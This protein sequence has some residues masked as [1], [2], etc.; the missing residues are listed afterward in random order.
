MISVGIIGSGFGVRGH[1][2]AFHRTGLARVKS[3]YSPNLSRLQ[4]LSRLH[5]I[6]IAATRPEEVFEDP[7]IDLVVIASPNWTHEHYMRMGV[8]N[9]KHLL[10]EKPLGHTAEQSER[11][12]ALV[13]PDYPKW[14]AINHQ[15]RF[16]PYIRFMK[17]VSFSGSLGRIIGLRVA[18]ISTALANDRL[19][20]NWS[21]DE[22]SGG[23]VR[24][25]MGSHLVD[26]AAF[27]TGERIARIDAQMNP[28]RYTRPRG[29]V[30]MSVNV[31]STFL[32]F[33]ETVNGTNVQL[34][35]NAAAFSGTALDIDIFFDRGEIRF[36]LDRKIRIFK[37]G[38]SVV[39][40]IR[41]LPCVTAEERANN[42]SIFGGSV[43]YFVQQLVQDIFD[44]RSRTEY[45]CSLDDAIYVSKVLDA[46][47]A[48]YRTGR[49]VLIGELGG[50]RESS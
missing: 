17:E 12:A 32:A 43:G 42:T 50:Y 36:D 7:E 23:G 37:A 48:A 10:C 41:V 5:K 27:L 15:L 1:L 4:E 46:A 30:E 8:M 34:S 31:S 6:E 20:W 39:E 21:F 44:G 40:N 29:D 19:Q 45:A 22:A 14:I 9:E 11:I 33:C 2:P 49:S 16:N 28:I 35:T 18:H 25:A 24:L 38:T 13:P 47:L 26:L 3:I